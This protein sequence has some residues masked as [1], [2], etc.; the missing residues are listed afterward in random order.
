[1]EPSQVSL[2]DLSGLI[3]TGVGVRQNTSESLA[4]FGA[5]PFG[6]SAVGSEGSQPLQALRT[7]SIITGSTS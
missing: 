4:G 7:R 2:H 5:S 3:Y 1:M 6:S